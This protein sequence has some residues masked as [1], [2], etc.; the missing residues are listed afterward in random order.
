[1]YK[2]CKPPSKEKWISA[3]HDLVTCGKK[4][5]ISTKAIQAVIPRTHWTY[6]VIL[7]KLPLPNA[8]HANVVH[9]V[10]LAIQEKTAKMAT[11]VPMEN[12]EAQA[13]MLDQMTSSSQFH[14]NA[15]AMLHQAAQENQDQQDQSVPQA[16]LD[17]QAV[18]V[19]QVPKDHQA[20]QAQLAKPEL[21]DP[22]DQA[23]NQ[24]YKKKVVLA[25]Q[26]Q[27]ANQ[28]HQAPQDQQDQQVAQAKMVNQVVQV[29]QEM[30]A[31][32]APLAKLALQALQETMVPQVPLA[33]ALTAHQLVWLQDIK[34]STSDNNISAISSISPSSFTF[35]KKT[36]FV[37]S[38]LF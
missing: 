11:P 17:H 9:Q 25:Q 26:A 35:M 36:N 14:H 30:L 21:T 33:L 5:W 4:C 8:A 18:T 13:P 12:Q 20:H 24:E 34:N 38:F 16:M 37:A 22:K 32:Q 28:V 6:C 3:S 27:S 7:V 15:T 31:A 29:P 2:R 10:P 19:N 23:E 1:M